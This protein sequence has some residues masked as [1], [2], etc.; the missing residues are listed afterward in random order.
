MG[1]IRPATTSNSR[2]RKMENIYY[3]VSLFIPWGLAQN[4]FLVH[5]LFNFPQYCFET[6]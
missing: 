1:N 3:I 6:N 4:F 5:I 2:Y